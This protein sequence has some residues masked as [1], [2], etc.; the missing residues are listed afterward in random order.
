ME[1][2]IPAIFIL[3]SFVFSASMYAYIAIRIRCVRVPFFFVSGG[4]VRA[5]HADALIAKVSVYC[6]MWGN[7]S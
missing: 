1:A 7:Q 4:S 2:V 6:S 3:F 5:K